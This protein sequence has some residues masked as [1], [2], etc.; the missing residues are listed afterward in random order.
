MGLTILLGT[1]IGAYSTSNGGE[2]STK[3]YLSDWKYTGEGQIRD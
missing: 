1:L 2:G 3:A